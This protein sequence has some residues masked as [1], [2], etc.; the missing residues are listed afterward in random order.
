MLDFAA[1]AVDRL[2]VRPE[3]TSPTGVV[4]VTEAFACELSLRDGGIGL[5]RIGGAGEAAYVVAP[6]AAR[7]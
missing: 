7:G 4:G 1:L 6:P 3:W 5:S 2:P